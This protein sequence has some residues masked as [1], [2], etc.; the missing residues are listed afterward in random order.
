M[1]EYLNVG[2]LV[3]THGLKGEVKVVRIT[4]FEE[5]FEPGK[6]LLLFK[7][8]S[9]QPI[10]LKIKT[11]RQHKAF[12]MLTFEGYTN[13]NQ[14]EPFK[15]GMLKVEK[16]DVLDLEENEYFYHDIIGC[17]VFTIDGEVIGQVKEI[18]APGANDVWVISADGKK[19]V[20]IPYIEEVV[21]DINIEEKVIKINPLEGLLPD[22]N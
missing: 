9:N 2:K 1:V 11:H 5:R 21:T 15:E 3:N 16:D 17:Q 4:D 14:V 12:D 10:E 22:E 13:I 6:S 19:D 20:L 7:K 18:L 8:N